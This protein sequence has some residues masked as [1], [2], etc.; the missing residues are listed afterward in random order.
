MGQTCVGSLTRINIIKTASCVHNSTSEQ[1]A[2]A[3]GGT[4][5]NPSVIIPKRLIDKLDSAAARGSDNSRSAVA[6]ALEF[7][8][9]VTP[10]VT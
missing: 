9:N 8:P 3:I 7:P 4:D 6:I 2:L 5:V 10:L 1:T